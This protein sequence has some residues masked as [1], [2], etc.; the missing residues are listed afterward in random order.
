MVQHTVDIIP[1][2]LILNKSVSPW[3]TRCMH[4][5]IAVVHKTKHLAMMCQSLALSFSDASSWKHVLMN[6]RRCHQKWLAGKSTKKN[7][8]KVGKSSWSTMFF[9]AIHV[10][11]PEG[12][13]MIAAW[14]SLQQLR[15]NWGKLR[16][17]LNHGW[18]NPMFFVRNNHNWW[19]QLNK[20]CLSLS[21][22]I[23]LNPHVCW[24]VW[25]QLWLVIWICLQIGFPKNPLVYQY[26]S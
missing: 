1:K 8:R 9:S 19:P 4:L 13:L 3:V 24:G 16:L 12:N 20:I 15:N 18:P 25:S 26:F 21:R 23:M 14:Y 10:L 7:I 22:W 17:D 11:L 6:A 2:I 5:Q